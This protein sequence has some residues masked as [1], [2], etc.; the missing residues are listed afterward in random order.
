MA[1]RDLVDQHQREIE[2]IEDLIPLD[3]YVEALNIVYEDVTFNY[4]QDSFEP[5][6]VDDLPK[7]GESDSRG[8]LS[9]V[10]ALF[11]QR[12]YME[13]D[14]FGDSFDKTGV[15]EEVAKKM[16]TFENLDNFP[17]LKVGIGKLKKMLEE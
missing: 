15:I 10:E 12:G 14:F 3:V 7:L 16:E 4:Q 5:I 9:R 17:Q 1:V 6:A 8:I 2:T 13:K 11:V